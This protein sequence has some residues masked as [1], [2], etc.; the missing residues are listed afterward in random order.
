VGEK[1]GAKANASAIAGTRGGRRVRRTPPAAHNLPARSG[2]ITQTRR[3]LLRESQLLGKCSCIR[4][5]AI[6]ALMQLDRTVLALES[7]N[8]GRPPCQAQ[9]PQQMKPFS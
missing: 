4:R 1:R 5:F 2:G 9:H 8:Q 7:K 3:T 6:M